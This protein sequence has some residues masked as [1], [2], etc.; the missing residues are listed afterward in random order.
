MRKVK[1]NLLRQKIVDIRARNF[2]DAISISTVIAAFAAIGV[3]MAIA[4]LF[5]MSMCKRLPHW[6]AE[7]AQFINRF[8]N[9]YNVFLPLGVAIVIFAF[10]IRMKLSRAAHEIIT[11]L[12]VRLIYI[13]AAIGVPCLMSSFIKW[14]FGR[15]RPKLFHKIGGID[16]HFFSWTTDGSGLS[17]PSGHTT[18]AFSAA[19]AFSTL[20]PQ[21]RIP[22]FI[23]AGLVGAARVVL[24]AHY[25]SDVIGGALCGIVF[26]SL[27]S[28]VFARQRLGLVVT[29]KGT[30]QPKAWPRLGRFVPLA[31]AALGKLRERPPAPVMMQTAGP[32]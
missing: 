32:T 3:C 13:F 24:G 11:L 23:L 22:L 5:V 14:I 30:I 8:G 16:F 20:V 2:A 29:E 28:R 9:G 4:D 31:E 19:L 17:F 10:T 6:C 26:A 7:V 12:A 1:F 18:L 15:V 27:V 21:T 25:P